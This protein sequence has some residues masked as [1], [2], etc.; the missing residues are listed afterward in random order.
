MKRA[1]FEIRSSRDHKV[2]KHAWNSSVRAVESLVRDIAR[3]EGRVYTL[4]EET[5]EKDGSGKRISGR[6]VWASGDRQIVF[7]IR[8]VRPESTMG[9]S[10]DI[11]LGKIDV[12]R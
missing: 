8:L 9:N 6:R 12:H 1:T 2:V 11:R 5:S 3:E 4:A 10:D 7:E